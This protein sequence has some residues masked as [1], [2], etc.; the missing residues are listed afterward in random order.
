MLHPTLR[1]WG[2]R[3]V[4]ISPTKFNSMLP[5]H[6]ISFTTPQAWQLQLLSCINKGFINDTHSPK[7]T[8]KFKLLSLHY[9]VQLKQVPWLQDCYSM[10]YVEAIATCMCKLNSFSPDSRLFA[11]VDAKR[12]NKW[13]DP[14]MTID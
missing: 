9:I 7:S 14:S 10:K 13:P 6:Y 2:W 12:P 3:G 5:L 4:S 1:P 8:P 11:T